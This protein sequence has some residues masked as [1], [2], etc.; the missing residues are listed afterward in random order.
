MDQRG[1]RKGPAASSLAGGCGSSFQ[2][3]LSHGA[4][5]SRTAGPPTSG[6]LDVNEHTDGS[7]AMGSGLGLWG[8]GVT[9][10]SGKAGGGKGGLG[11]GVASASVPRLP[12]P[13][14]TLPTPPTP[15]PSLRGIAP[16]LAP[17][18]TGGRLSRTP[19]MTKAP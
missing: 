7:V 14:Q 12:A 18:A 1:G 10:D 4:L 6:G 17:A 8:E 2:G 3:L 19:A 11:R 9:G 15:V 16:C 5:S 13:C